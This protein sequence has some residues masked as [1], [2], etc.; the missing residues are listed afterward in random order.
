MLGRKLFH[1]RQRSRHRPKPPN[2]PRSRNALAFVLRDRHRRRAERLSEAVGK[3]R[4]ALEQLTERAGHQPVSPAAGRCCCGS[5]RWLVF[6]QWA[7]PNVGRRTRRPCEP[8]AEKAA[9]ISIP[10]TYRGFAIRGQ[11]CAKASSPVLGGRVAPTWSQWVP[12]T[13]R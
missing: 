13:N 2:Q 7:L 8:D 3:Q 5:R 6:G 9:K 12:P 1:P 10:N 4:R 11:F